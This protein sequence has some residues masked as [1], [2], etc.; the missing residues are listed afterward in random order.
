STIN[1]TLTLNLPEK[2]YTDEPIT[3]TGTY[4]IQN[5]ENYDTDILEQNQFNVYINGELDQTVDT[6]EFNI[7][8]TTSFMIL[9]VQPTISQTR[10]SAIIRASTLNITLEPIT[11]TIGETTRITAQITLI[12][13]DENI[14]VNSGRVYFKVNGK[15][16]RDSETG[17][18]LYAD[19]SDN[20]AT[21]DY[22]VPKTWNDET[23]IEAVFTGNVE[24]P[25][26]TSNTVNPTIVTPETSETVFTVSDVTTKAGEEVTITV[27][28]KN[29]DNGKVV[30]K[31]NGRT[32]KASDDK[33][34]AKVSGDTTTFTYVVPKTFKAG[35][36][37]IKAVYTSASAK[38]DAVGVLRVG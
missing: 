34:Y 33:L 13:D 1:D 21:L 3:I 14:E 12:E 22:N 4:T 23:T 9:T 25:Q 29:L 15:I 19:V 10:K 16:L 30:L 35:E 27:S 5:P 20:T 36:Y 11:A 6:L 8:P 17:R 7:T 28:T 2:T 38:L 24:I 26:K 18:I 31:I 32:V 37:A